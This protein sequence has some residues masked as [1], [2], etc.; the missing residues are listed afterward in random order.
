MFAPK[1]YCTLTYSLDSLVEPMD[2]IA[3]SITKIA[4][5][6]DSIAQSLGSIDASMTVW[7]MPGM[8]DMFE[9]LRPSVCEAWDNIKLKCNEYIAVISGDRF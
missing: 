8:A 9:T 6:F 3:K 7:G 5:I 2:A 1:I 4:L